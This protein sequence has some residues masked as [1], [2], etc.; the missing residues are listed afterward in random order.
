MYFDSYYPYVVLNGVDGGEEQG[1]VQGMLV[2]PTDLGKKVREADK[3]EQEGVLYKRTVV[4]V[5]AEGSDEAV[6]AYVYV[7]DRC[8]PVAIPVEGGDWVVA[9]KVALAVASLQL[10][11]ASLDAE[12][13]RRAVVK[14]N[15]DLRLAKSFLKWGIA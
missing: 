14:A 11:T 7:R 9:D 15:G 1:C 12:T 8:G 2:F 5:C 3:I 4:M 10:D 6:P 13:A